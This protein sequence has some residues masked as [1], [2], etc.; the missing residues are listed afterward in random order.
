MP[1]QASNDRR[2]S[3]EYFGQG[4]SGYTAGRVEGDRSLQQQI[5][6]RNASFPP[7]EDEHVPDLGVDERFVGLGSAPWAPEPEDEP[8]PSSGVVFAPPGA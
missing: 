7:G 5:E 2:H 6:A 3:T 8:G 1:T 4:Q